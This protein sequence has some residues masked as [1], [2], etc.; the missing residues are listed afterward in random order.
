MLHHPSVVI[1]SQ[2]GDHR[3]LSVFAV[4]RGST[5][6]HGVTV[7][8]CMYSIDPSDDEAVILVFQDRAIRV[9]L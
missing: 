8:I 1:S 6:W 5:V 2:L 7:A 9:A 3:E 4:F